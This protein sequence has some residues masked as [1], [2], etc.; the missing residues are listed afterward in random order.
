M[1]RSQFVSDLGVGLNAGVRTDGVAGPGAARAKSLHRP[2]HLLAVHPRQ[3][4]VPLSG[5]HSRGLRFVE[6]RRF[7]EDAGVS[8]LR[9]HD[10]QP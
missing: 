10:P 3:V 7:R 9:G 4:S 6:G 8:A 2:A 5:K 1:A